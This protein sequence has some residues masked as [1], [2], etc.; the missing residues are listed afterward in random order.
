MTSAR[1]SALLSVFGC[2]VVLGLLPIL[3]N[4]RPAGSDGLA[5][6]V[7]L[8]FWQLLAALPLFLRESRAEAGMPLWRGRAGWSRWRRARCSLWRPG[9]MW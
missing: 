4:A 1:R 6:A 9:S 8:T 2:L 5:F 3:A 7:L